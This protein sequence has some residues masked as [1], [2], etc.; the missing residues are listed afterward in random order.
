MH[1]RAISSILVEYR[2]HVAQE[3]FRYLRCDDVVEIWLWKILVKPEKLV[4]SVRVPSTN[5]IC[6]FFFEPTE[7]VFAECR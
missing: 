1:A 6:F 7:P 3:T 4:F 2:E 5:I